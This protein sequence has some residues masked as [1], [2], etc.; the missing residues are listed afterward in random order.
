MATITY[1][2]QTIVEKCLQSIFPGLNPG[3]LNQ[4][5]SVLG[6][7]SE[8][9]N[10]PCKYGYLPVSVTNTT[11]V[12]IPILIDND[13]PH[14]P[15]KNKTIAIVAKDPSRDPNDKMLVNC[16]LTNKCS[17]F[18]SPIVGTPYAYHYEES[19]YPD[20]LVYRL[21]INKLLKQGYKVYLTDSHKVFKRNPKWN[22][23]KIQRTN[24]IACL[25]Y[26]LDSI[27]PKPQLV[28]T[29]GKD[30]KKYVDVINSSH[31]YNVVS[32]L[33]PSQTNWD[34]WKLWIF[35][36]AYRHLNT[37]DVNWD[38]YARRLWVRNNMFGNPVIEGDKMD[39]IISEI[40][41]EII[42]NNL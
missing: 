13:D 40:A 7:V 25:N 9:H 26:E 36:Q 19:I 31:S 14:I 11:G 6:N 24:E 28:V 34:H 15:Q 20:T 16:M 21:I 35:E 22:P 17:I 8:Y 41:L 5:I 37:Y 29:F 27:N 12:D 10:Q 38:N 1:P 32:L 30:A 33:H 2:T 23:N 4:S 3:C 18:Q 39:N 42:F